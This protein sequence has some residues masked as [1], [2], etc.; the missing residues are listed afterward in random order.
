LFLEEYPV[1]SSKSAGSSCDHHS[2]IPPTVGAALARAAGGDPQREALV[3][4]DER[5]TYGELHARSLK[6]ARAL[7]AAG[8]ERGDHVA[9]C[10]GNGVAWAVIFH[11]IV[12][13][14]AVCVPINTRLS[15]PEIAT[16]LR[17]S[18]VR[19]LITVGRLLKVDFVAIVRQICVSVDVALPSAELPH[20]RHI[21]IVDGEAPRACESFDNFIAR[22]EG[23]PLPAE[24]DADDTALIQF[25]SGSTSFPKAVLLSHRNMVTDAYFLGLRM[26]IT[27][28]DRYLSARP[29][30]HVAGSTLAVVLASVHGATLVTL[31][32]FTGEAALAAIERERCTLTSGNDT[33]YLMMLNSP[34]FRP[35]SYSLRGGWAA[36]SPTIMRRVVEEFGA[37][38]TVTGYGQSE[39]SPNILASDH[40]DPVEGRIAGWMHPHPGLDVKICDPATGEELPAS[41]RGEIRVRGWCVMKGY[42][43]DEAATKAT[44]TADGFLKTGDIGVRHEDGRI[45]FVGRL[46]EII[47]VG[48]ENVAPADIEDV[49]N[50]HPKV[51]QA[52]VFALPDPRLIEVPGAY[53]VPREGEALTAE[54]LVEWARERLAG[55]KIPKHIAVIES[56]DIIGLTASAKVPK[57]LLIEHALKHFG[58]EEARTRS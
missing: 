31:V 12:R 18:E 16:Q 21:V 48:G 58:L 35:G 5:I 9:L 3:D 45:A 50:G 6:V 17:L 10:A 36:I 56:F 46:K 15:P 54:E 24:P 8:I 1:P 29:F 25:T 2:D 28:E 27:A 42:Y 40:R 20:L 30:F 22:G 32:R 13:L 34:A 55:F 19:L 57:R 14:G 26:G 49:L 52:Q 47:R 39:A 23:R 11:G 51:R 33:M 43:N 4:G 53:V 44:I 7:A 41:A 37:S 38:A